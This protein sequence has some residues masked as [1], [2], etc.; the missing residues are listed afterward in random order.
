MTPSNLKAELMNGPLAALGLEL[1]KGG[2]PLSIEFSSQDHNAVIE[3]TRDLVRIPSLFGHEKEVAETVARQMRSLGFDHVEIDTAGSVIGVIEGAADGPILLLDAHIDTVDVVPRE[4]WSHDPFGGELVA[5]RIYGRGSSD[6]KGALAGMIYAAA[7]VDRSQIAGRVVISASV[8]EEI[9]EG[10]ALR[11]VMERYPPDFVVI[12]EPSNLDL[13]RGG[14][15]RAEFVLHTKGRPAHT[16]VPYQGVNA[17][18]KMM[19]VIEAVEALPMP[20]DPV[21]GRGVIAL[22]GIISEPHPPQSVVPSLCHATYE[23]RLVPAD[24]L[25]GL[26]MELRRVCEEAGAPDTEIELAVADIMTY[27]GMHWQHP[28]WFPAWLIDE[29]HELVQKALSGL[30]QVGLEPQLSAYQF[31]TNAAYSAGEAGVPTIGFGPSPE[32]MAHTVDEYLEVEQLLRASQGY[33]GI[34]TALLKSG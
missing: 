6:M 10:R 7:S 22:A 1:T 21:A 20:Q 29:D 33:T 8:A 9:I 31:C 11:H 18:H 19:R 28:K 12:G 17:V 13:V 32:T 24:T 3:F 27:T 30:R 15:G 14:R 34:I 26:M 23:R 4:A 2:K 16:S 25:D 5:G